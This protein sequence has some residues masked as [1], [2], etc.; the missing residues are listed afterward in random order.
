MNKFDKEMEEVTSNIDITES[1]AND[2]TYK[3]SSKEA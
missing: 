2:K 1:M 3:A